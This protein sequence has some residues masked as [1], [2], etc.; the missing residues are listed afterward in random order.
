MTT[1]IGRIARL[2]AVA[3]LASL[4]VA[5]P[6][7]G[8]AN[9]DDGNGKPG[10]SSGEI[11]FWYD[12]QN[13]YQKQFWHAG[14]HAGNNFWYYNNA[15]GEYY[16]SGRPVQDNAL[17]STN[18]DTECWIHVGDLANGLWVRKLVENNWSRTYL[19]A[20]NNRNDRH[21]RCRPRN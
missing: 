16:V 9:A 2:G 10:C 18:K 20:V 5:L 13:Y 8:A 1:T 19:G 7:G 14:N 12:S 4:A 21:D 3:I 17:E 11:C 15:E 6:V